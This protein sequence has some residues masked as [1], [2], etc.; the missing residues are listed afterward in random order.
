MVERAAAVLCLSA[1]AVALYAICRE[2]RCG[3]FAAGFGAAAWVLSESMLRPG[4]APDAPTP[5]LLVP[6]ALAG[7]FSREKRR[8]PFIALGAACL[9][10]RWRGPA[11]AAAG[12]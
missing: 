10:F 9:A 11:G 12:E 4:A 1:A 7:A 8:W 6:F 2:L 5:T 3:R